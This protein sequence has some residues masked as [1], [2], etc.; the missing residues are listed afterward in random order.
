MFSKKLMNL[1]EEGGE[2]Q[3][4]SPRSMM[5]NFSLMFLWIISV[6]RTG[7]KY[8]LELNEPFPVCSPIYCCCGI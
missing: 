3:L 7:Q 6:E 1:L 2:L 8:H 4:T 5:W